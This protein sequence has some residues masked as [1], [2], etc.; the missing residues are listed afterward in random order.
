MLYFQISSGDNHQIQF[1][2]GGEHHFQFGG[3]G[4]GEGMGRGMI[5]LGNPRFPKMNI[6][7]AVHMFNVRMDNKETE[8]LFQTLKNKYNSNHDDGTPVF[9]EYA[10]W[11]LRQFAQNYPS[12]SSR[13]E[14]FLSG[15]HRGKNPYRD[16]SAC[17][18]K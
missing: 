14:Q 5:I 17:E 1:F 2:W 3:R 13:V 12:Y 9:T 4:D 11:K 8:D 10:T 7:R 6:Y 15:P 18:M 16:D